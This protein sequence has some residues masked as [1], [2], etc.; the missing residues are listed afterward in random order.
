MP[1]M[2]LSSCG[3]IRFSVTLLATGFASVFVLTGRIVGDQENHGKSREIT[4]RF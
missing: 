3:A 1:R 2:I 4:G